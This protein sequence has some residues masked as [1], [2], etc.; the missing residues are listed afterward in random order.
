[1]A[2][3]FK[4]YYET[5]GVSKTA[6]ADEIRK[7]FRKLARQ[8]HP[9]VSKDKKKA[10]EKFKEINEAYEVLSDPEKRKRYDTLGA[11]WERGGMPGGGGAGGGHGFPPGGGNYT[12]STGNGGEEFHFGGTGFSDFFE[13]FFGGGRAAADPFGGGAT[14]FPPRRA[15]RGEDV[16]ADILVTFEEALNGSKRKISLKRPGNSKT[17]TYDIRIPAGVREGQRIRLAGQG[18]AGSKG[19]GAGDLYL[20]VKFAQHPEF[21]AEGSDLIH[22]LTLDAWEAVLGG[23]KSVPTLEGHARLKIPAGTQSGQ[24]F[25][26]KK[27]GLVKQDKTR[28]D[29]YVVIDIAIPKEITAKQRELWEKLAEEI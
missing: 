16:E 20:R 28:G 26:L 22:E 6:T 21:R 11:D 29:L 18:E 17:E 4:D 23:E 15:R 12:W 1:M 27:H 25:R 8:H 7:A 2:V 5:L 19:A 24:R 3:Q 13:Q 9:D 14:D 10:E